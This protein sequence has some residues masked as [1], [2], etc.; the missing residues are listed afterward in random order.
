MSFLQSS[1]FGQEFV[2]YRKNNAHY[3]RTKFSNNI[4][5]KGIGLVP[6]V[7]DSVD[8][9]LSILLGNTDNEYRNYGK[10]YTMHMDTIVYDF[11]NT[12][13]IDIEN[14]NP[15]FLKGKKLSLALEDGTIINTKL[16]LGYIY[17]KHKNE[18]DNILYIL[19]TQETTMYGYIMSILRYLGILKN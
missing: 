11:A 17:K 13:F 3:E 14:I 10:E 6:I 1:L 12:I 4:R 18:K 7:I 5:K 16:T 19:L 8:N 2:N 9:E 15:D